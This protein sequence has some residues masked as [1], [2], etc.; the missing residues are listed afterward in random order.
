VTGFDSLTKK[1]DQEIRGV[2]PGL[3][4]QA[5]SKGAKVYEAEVGE[6]YRYYDWAS[7]TKVVFSVSALMKAFESR[8]FDPF[9]KVNTY[10]S[11]FP[12]ETVCANHL[13]THSAGFQWWQA[14]YEH[15]DLSLPPSERFKQVLEM[16][17]QE[18]E[19]TPNEKSVYSD[20][21]FLVL[22]RLLES[23][24]QT[25][26]ID[27]WQR[28]NSELELESVHFNLNNV[29]SFDPKLYAPTES[30]A[31]RGRVLQ[32]E[33]HDENTWALGGVSA[34]AGLF[35]TIDDLAKW[36]LLIRSAYFNDSA[37][38]FE[39]ETVALFTR[40]SIS[41]DKGDWALGFMMPTP[42]KASCGDRFS[43]ESF[44]HTGF[45]GT[46]IWL[47]PKKDLLIC[48][49]SNR[50]FPTRDNKKFVEL[51]PRIHNWISDTIESS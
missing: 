14:F 8:M 20:L 1:L 43:A 38:G 31:W 7:L 42:G 33:V 30:C 49:L 51:R 21:D 18:P 40:R 34:H 32:G 47:D 16:I 26:L 12:F 6:T 17:Y 10:V 24:Y 25:S 13:L 50:V 46:S 19:P 45:T 2:T 28:L 35:G 36:G 37:S 15:I 3:K 23:I 44:G 4:V 48:I 29:P 5:F 39:H 22:G 11:D 27:I 41:V 9:E